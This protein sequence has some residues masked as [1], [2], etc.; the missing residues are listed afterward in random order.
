[1]KNSAVVYG[2]LARSEVV[3]HRVILVHVDRDFLSARKQ[4]VLGKLVNVGNELLLVRPGHEPHATGFFGH[5]RDRDPSGRLL[6][7]PAHA[8]VGHVLMPGHNFFGSGLLDE[9]LAR[10]NKQVRT[11]HALD[12]IQHRLGSRYFIEQ[13][14]DDLPVNPEILIDIN[15]FVGIR[16]LPFNPFDLFPKLNRALRRKRSDRLD[17][18]V[19]MIGIQLVGSEC[20]G[21][22]GQLLAFCSAPS[23]FCESIP[24]GE[25][26][27]SF[28]LV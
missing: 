24:V 19:L 25:N 12:R 9:K 4:V 5:V 13:R 18:A 22:F 26:L 2:H 10:P 21:H 20:S 7:R 17:K 28:E 16:A 8:P 15:G 27:A 11:Q 14:N 6:V 1:M 3:K 23:R